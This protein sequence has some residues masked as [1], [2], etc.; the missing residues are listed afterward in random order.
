MSR[1]SGVGNHHHHQTLLLNTPPEH[2]VLQFPAPTLGTQEDCDI[3]MF[4][5]KVCYQEYLLWEPNTISMSYLS[6]DVQLIS[7]AYIAITDFF[8]LINV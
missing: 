7:K 3:V 2:Q 6:A 4:V 1:R 8:L 5:T